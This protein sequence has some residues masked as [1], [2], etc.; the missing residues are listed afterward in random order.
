M[1]SL[2]AIEASTAAIPTVPGPSAAG[3]VSCVAAGPEFAAGAVLIVWPFGEMAARA[4]CTD[5]LC[6]GGE[7]LCECEKGKSA[8]KAKRKGRRIILGDQAVE[9]C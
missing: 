5:P 9:V 1:A 7:R 4:V 2:A 6:V 3:A 8:M